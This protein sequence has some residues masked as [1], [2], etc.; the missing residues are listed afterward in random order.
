MLRKIIVALCS[1][2][3]VVATFAVVATPRAEAQGDSGLRLVSEFLLSNSRFVKYPHVVAGRNQ[4]TVTAY[5]NRDKV[6]AWNKVAAAT[7]FPSPFEVGGAEGTP[8]WSSTSVALAPDGTL[9]TVWANQPERTIYLRQRDPRG[10]WGPRRVVESRLGFGVN[11][12]VAVTTGNQVFVT[13]REVDRPI[14]YRISNNGG[15]DWSDRRD[16]TDIIAYKGAYGLAAGP[17]GR[18]GITFTAGV[19]DKLQ[20]FVGLWNGSSFVTNRI[21]SGGADFADPTI[22]F[23][24]QGRPIVA[25]RGVATSGGNAGAFFAEQQPD[26]GWP[27]SRLVGGAVTDNVGVSSDEQGNLHMAWIGAPSGSS[28]IYYA[29]KPAG[30]NF[31]GPIASG[32]SAAVYN[33]RLSA[34]VAGGTYAHVVSEEFS[35]SSSFLRYSLFSSNVSIF[36]GEPVVGDGTSKVA[37]T[38]DGTVKLSFRTITGKPNQIRWRWQAA[39]TDAASD[40]GGW[41]TFTNE[42]RIPVPENI[43]NDTSCQPVVLYTQLRDTVTGLIEPTARP[44]TVNLDGVVEAQVSV[45]NPFAR[46]SA[47]EIGGRTSLA[48]TEGAPGGAPN[49]T[50]VPLTWLNVTSDTDCSGITV[51]DIGSTPDSFEQTIVINDGAFAGII[52]LPDLINVKPGNVPVYVRV[53]DGA[54]N[55]RIFSVPVIFDETK[56]L[57]Q[58]GAV[59]AT[60]APK[61]DIL[62]DLTFSQVLVNDDYPGG[63]WGV[64]VAN[65]TEEVGDPINQLSWEVRAAPKNRTADSEGRTSFTVKDWSLANGLDAKDLVPGEDYYIYVRFLDGAGNPTDKVIVTRVASSQLVKPKTTLPILRR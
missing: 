21:S 46:A 62:Q 51:A 40:S 10:N 55:A 5:V 25:F 22:T 11:P 43:R 28:T 57:Y 14:R 48:A 50:R 47:Q 3:M 24:P 56:P 34:S 23:S 19:D 8:D 2:A 31:R 64:W 63:Y 4:V 52:A 15:N 1:L 29:F 33:P 39:P 18:L 32:N 35:G 65:A 26:G 53:R 36:G 13:W 12:E 16:V 9:Y 6:F 7:S 27:R 42:L 30:G 41:T 49:Y 59:E 44:T 38:A 61:A 37:P 17:G 58:S 54:G 20:I 60:A 45:S